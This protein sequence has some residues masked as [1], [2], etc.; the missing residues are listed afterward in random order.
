MTLR[1]GFDMDGTLA[2]FAAAFREVEGNLFGAAQA[3][4]PLDPESEEQ[5]QQRA[6]G[7]PSPP[8]ADG[9]PTPAQ[10]SASHRASRRRQD[11]VWAAIQA[12]PDFWETLQPIEPGAV[13][14][15]QDLS[16]RH[17]WEVFFITQRPETAGD[18]VQRQTQRWLQRQGFALPSVLVL[19]GSRGTAARALRLDYLV[20]DSSRNCLDVLCDS[21]AKPLLIVPDGDAVATAS[22]RSLGVGTVTSVVAALDVLDEASRAA[23]QPGVLARIASLVGWRDRS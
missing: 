10:W 15:I 5:A 4:R 8:A 9:A 22:A 21:P 17:R 7:T 6:A 23:A 2:D 20:D 19:S 13:A 1:I 3:T 12:V 11:A 18:T 14:R 16:L